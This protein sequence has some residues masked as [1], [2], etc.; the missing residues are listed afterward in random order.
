M[1][2]LHTDAPNIYRYIVYISGIEVI[3]YA[4]FVKSLSI[5]NIP[6]YFAPD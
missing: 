4:A 6:S 2:Y 5:D 1:A 3:P